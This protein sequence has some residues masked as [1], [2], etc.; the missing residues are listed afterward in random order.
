M[1]G[2]VENLNSETGQGRPPVSLVLLVALGCVLAL[3]VTST[4]WAGPY[5]RVSTELSPARSTAECR[6][7]AAKA[8]GNL[9][10]RKQLLVDQKNPRL[11]GTRDSTAYVECIFVGKNEQRR[12]QW[13]FHISIASTN[14]Q[15]SAQLLKLLR[16]E[17]GSFV[18]ID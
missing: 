13:I 8:L 1:S 4:A 17:L 7:Q 6:A 16:E 11:G 5:L 18:R 10:K 12:D 14:G 3:A 2:I 9:Q 15:E